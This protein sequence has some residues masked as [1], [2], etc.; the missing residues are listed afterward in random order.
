MTLWYK[1]PSRKKKSMTGSWNTTGVMDGVLV[2]YKPQSEEQ[3]MCCSVQCTEGPSAFSSESL[4]THKANDSY[5]CRV[6]YVY[7]IIQINE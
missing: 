5:L 7:Q 4:P 6:N 1:L 3:S 2:Q